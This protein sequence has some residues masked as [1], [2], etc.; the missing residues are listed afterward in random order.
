MPASSA[1]CAHLV[2]L[3]QPLGP[4][5]VRRM[6]GGAG[7]FRDGLMFGLIADDALYLKADEHNRGDFEARG[8]GPFTYQAKSKTTAL[9]YYQ[10]PPELMEDPEALA[11]WADKAYQA[12]LRAAAAKRRGTAKRRRRG[13]AR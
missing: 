13:Q 4:V 1:F 12:A 10:A 9:S 8:L 6:F 3:M 5:A 2:D 11:A 7:V